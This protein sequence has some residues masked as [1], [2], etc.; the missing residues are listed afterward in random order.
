MKI[1]ILSQ[2]NKL[3]AEKDLLTTNKIP[4]QITTNLEEVEKYLI[5]YEILREDMAKMWSTKDLLGWDEREL[6]VWHHSLKHFPFK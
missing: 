5:G 4:S 6:L 2:D 3:E 1:H